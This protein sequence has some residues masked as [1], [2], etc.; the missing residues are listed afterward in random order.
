MNLS[1]IFYF[2]SRLFS[3]KMIN[4]LTSSFPKQGYW[5]L[6]IL[7]EVILDNIMQN[8]LNLRMDYKRRFLHLGLLLISSYTVHFFEHW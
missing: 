7:E 2:L 4:Q 1:Y 3:L 5:V 6:F 8:L